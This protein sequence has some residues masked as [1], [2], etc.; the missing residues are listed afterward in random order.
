[1]TTLRELN[2]KVVDVL[3]L[4]RAV[5][6]KAEALD[7]ANKEQEYL[8]VFEKETGGYDKYPLV[9][10]HESNEYR[11]LQIPLKYSKKQILDALVTQQ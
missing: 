2:G 5:S 9:L 7:S 4:A 3:N 11:C 8:L 6:F 10:H 1:M